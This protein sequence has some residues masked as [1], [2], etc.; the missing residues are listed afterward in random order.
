MLAS[1]VQY[2][3]TATGGD[4]N[5]GGDG[6]KEPGFDNAG[7]AFKGSFDRRR[8]GD[9]TEIA[10]D[11]VVAA[12]GHESLAACGHT[13]HSHAAQAGELPPGRLPAEARHLDG[14]GAEAAERAAQL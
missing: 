14:H 13:Q 12:I 9:R 1:P 6:D 11:D 2:F 8:V 4:D 5:L 3:N 7:N 10:I